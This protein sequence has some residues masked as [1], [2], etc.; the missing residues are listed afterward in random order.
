MNKFLQRFGWITGLLVVIII[1]IIAVLLIT[2]RTYQAN[3]DSQLNRN[4]LESKQ[5]QP[6]EK[7]QNETESTKSEKMET[8]QK[9]ISENPEKLE[10]LKIEEQYSSSDNITESISN[11]STFEKKIDKSK[12]ALGKESEAEE[13]SVLDKSEI[14]DDEK[15]INDGVN[16][17][18]RTAAQSKDESQQISEGTN[19]NETEKKSSI[20]DKQPDLKEEEKLKKSELSE[21]DTVEKSVSEIID[22]KSK[23]TNSLKV[24]TE[25]PSSKNE[26][27]SLDVN[28]ANEVSEENN[29]RNSMQKLEVDIVRIEPAG[30]TIVAGTAEPGSEVEVVIDDKLVGSAKSDS[31]GNFVVMGEIK[32]SDEPQT[33]K[34]RSRKDKELRENILDTGGVK[35]AGS[36]NQLE[37]VKQEE[38]YLADGG[39]L[40]KNQWIFSDDIFVV[41]PITENNSVILQEKNLDLPTII[42]SSS[43]EIK[44]VQNAPSS[45]VNK[46]TL[47]TISYSDLGEAVLAGRAKPEFKIFVY[48]NNK[49]FGTG[50]AGSSGGW[51]V[52]LTGLLPGVYTL[53]I[54]EVDGQGSVKSR[55]E[56]P[57]KRESTE[58]LTNMISGA[59]T[60]QPGNSLWRIARRIFGRGIRYIEIFEKN[61]HLIKDPDLIYPGQVF[62]IPTNFN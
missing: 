32:E 29:K 38:G 15:V 16:A 36:E 31:L 30:S 17:N 39:L 23:A 10:D 13:S 47:D 44:I 49:L 34:I 54:D 24:K 45:Y 2:D 3:K 62:S 5:V 40:G 9:E 53:R 48:I 61:S 41:L 4:K 12:T 28:R 43:D 1:I 59:I 14:L 60:V 35:K 56:T 57:F 50:G 20:D 42:Q 8:K 11:D 52:E 21:E 7:V 33:L 55:I 18:P 6:E 27:S 37:S 26:G 25:K 51:T 58:I 19:S 22:L 46:V